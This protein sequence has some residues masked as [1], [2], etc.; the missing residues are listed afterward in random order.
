MKKSGKATE[1]W[2]FRIKEHWVFT[3][4]ESAD[5]GNYI[6]KAHNGK[7]TLNLNDPVEK[8]VAAWLRKH[9]GCDRDFWLR[10]TFEDLDL[11]EEARLMRKLLAMDISQLASMLTTEEQKAYGVPPG[12]SDKLVWVIAI[13]EKTRKEEKNE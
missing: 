10:E 1:T 3:P 9:P 6:V 12:C 5:G 2:L 8:K 13:R 4:I 11:A 7:A